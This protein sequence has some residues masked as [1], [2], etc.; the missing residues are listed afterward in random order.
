[1]K[2][3][4]FAV[5]RLGRVVEAPHVGGLSLDRLKALEIQTK[6]KI[7]RRWSYRPFRDFQR[8]FLRWDIRDLVVTLRAIRFLIAVWS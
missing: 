8:D 3:G 5:S 1:M 2:P 4:S 6:G 7:R